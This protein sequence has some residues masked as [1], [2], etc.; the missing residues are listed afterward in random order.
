MQK[1]KLNTNVIEEGNLTYNSKLN[2]VFNFIPLD[3]ISII[4][5]DYKEH[6][7]YILYKNTQVEE[8]KKL[9]IHR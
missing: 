5:G 4:Y 2:F 8:K 7:R 9:N 1:D 3:L 6:F